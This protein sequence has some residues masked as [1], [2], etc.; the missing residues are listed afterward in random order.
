MLLEKMRLQNYNREKSLRDSR[1]K[2]VEEEK[3]WFTSKQNDLTNKYKKAMS[4]ASI[5]SSNNAHSVGY[6]ILNFDTS[7]SPKGKIQRTL[8]TK[9][10]LR[11]LARNQMIA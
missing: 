1:D 9:R 7:G 2:E 11:T 10:E 5:P 6:D 8:D 3:N 4:I